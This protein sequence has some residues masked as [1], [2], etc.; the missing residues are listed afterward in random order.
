MRWAALMLVGCGSAQAPI[1]YELDWMQG[2]SEAPDLSERL[3]AEA[4]DPDAAEDVIFIDCAPET[5]RLVETAPAATDTLTVLSYNIERGHSLDGVL[6]WL[7]SSSAP[8]PD[9]FLLSETDRG[10]SRTGSRHTTFELAEAL[11]MDFV[12]ATEFMEVRGQGS[13]VTEVCEHGNALLSRYPMANVD[14]FRHADNVSWYTAPED[15]GSSWSTRLGGRVG[16]VADI[17]VGDQIVHVSSLH[18]AS[19]ATDADV[20][21]AQATE[22]VAKLAERPFT[23]MGGGDLNAGTYVFD[24]QNG[25][26]NDG[27]SQAFLTQGYTDSHAELD[28]A[29]RI[30][31]DELPFVIDLIFA[32]AGSFAD[33]RICREDC[34]PFSDHYPIWADWTL[35][36]AL[37]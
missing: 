21:A 32:D 31:L 4:G 30:T 8:S 19:G 27:V 36:A 28:P 3:C 26:E 10:C 34:E 20:R 22:T 13:E 11:Q 16:I 5:G 1:E 14:V 9:V 6:E 18:L 15:R 2:G 37:E 12:Y 23:R 7:A 29:D 35:P 17:V 25:D 33:P 24:L